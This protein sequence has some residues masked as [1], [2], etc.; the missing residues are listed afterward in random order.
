MISATLTKGSLFTDAATNAPVV[1][2]KEDGSHRPLEVGDVVLYSV[3]DGWN[4]TT[5]VEAT[6]VKI[7]D[8]SI[9][10]KGRYS[11]SHRLNLDSLP[12]IDL[13]SDEPSRAPGQWNAKYVSVVSAADAAADRAEQSAKHQKRVQVDAQAA[14]AKV[15]GGTSATRDY[16]IRNVRPQAQQDAQSIVLARYAAEVATEEARITAEMMAKIHA[17]RPE[18]KAWVITS[19]RGYYAVNLAF[20]TEQEALD[21]IAAHAEVYPTSGSNFTTPEYKTV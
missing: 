13:A 16:L 8:R 9:M 6:V 20:E 1:W 7:T 19:G 11:K 14:A 3:S 2:N 18:V 21:Y 15:L 4:G 10:S 12:I 5:G 17:D